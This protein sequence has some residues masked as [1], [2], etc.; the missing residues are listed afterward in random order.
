MQLYISQIYC[1]A[2]SKIQLIKVLQFIT[3]T[4][5]QLY[6][7]LNLEMLAFIF[8]VQKCKLCYKPL[9]LIAS[10]ICLSLSITLS[11]KHKYFILV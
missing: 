11:C 8:L 3:C 9:L 2:S 7:V 4:W 5:T 1:D 10:W 6:I